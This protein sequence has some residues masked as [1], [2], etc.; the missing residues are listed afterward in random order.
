MEKKQVAGN[1]IAELEEIELMTEKI[2]EENEICKATYIGP[3][4][5]ILCC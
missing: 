3:I 1:I 4:F 2:Q 5:S